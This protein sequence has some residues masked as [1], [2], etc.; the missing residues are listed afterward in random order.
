MF[1]V[2]NVSIRYVSR[3]HLRFLVSTDRIRDVPRLRLATHC[4]QTISSQ[5][6]WRTH[7]LAAHVGRSHA[8]SPVSAFQK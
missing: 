3:E 6:Q 1:S 2:R 4:D 8:A 5:R 7:G